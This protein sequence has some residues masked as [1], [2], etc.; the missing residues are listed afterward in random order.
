MA[1][2]G[3]KFQATATDRQAVA[4]MMAAGETVETTCRA[5]G[6]SEPTLRKHFGRELAVGRGRIVAEAVGVLRKPLGSKDERV[7]LTAAQYILAR[8]AGWSERHGLD[9][10]GLPAGPLDIS[11][12]LVRPD[13]AQ[14]AED[15]EWREI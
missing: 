12:T 14:E 3:V 4:D 15:D 5:L 11:V 6:L 13:P 9:H 1:Q 8:K 2:R 7:A 10:S